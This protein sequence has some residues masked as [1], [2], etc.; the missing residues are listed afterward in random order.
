L[1]ISLLHR[2][3][4]QRTGGLGGAVLA[5]LERTHT[6]WVCCKGDVS[7]PTTGYPGPNERVLLVSP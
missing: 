7:P 6:Q 4:E 2:S 5:G 3:G 1:A